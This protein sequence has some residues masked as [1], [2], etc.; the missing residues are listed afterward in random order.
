MILEKAHHL[1]FSTV[2]G[3]QKLYHMPYFTIFYR[4]LSLYFLIRIDT[5]WCLMLIPL[6]LVPLTFLQ[7]SIT[8]I[9]F[10]APQGHYRSRLTDPFHFVQSDCQCLG[11][12]SQK[13]LSWFH[14]NVLILASGSVPT[15]GVC[16]ISCPVWG[17]H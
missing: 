14:V 11:V 7:V 2:Y 17:Y 9:S 15:P 1:V 12:I 8:F 16:V 6:N 3:K 4:H 10:V 13:F 5:F